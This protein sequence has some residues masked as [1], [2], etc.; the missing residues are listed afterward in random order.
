MGSANK[1]ASGVVWSTI[2]NV[3]SAIYGFI[4]VPILISYFGKSEY[5]LIGL[6]MSV[7]V[8]L[9]LMDL[10]FNSTNVR[11]FSAW[12]TKKDIIKTKKLF[13][14]SLAFYGTIGLLNGLILFIITLFSK[15]LFDLTPEQD[16]ILKHLFYILIV[17]AVISWYSSCFDQLI[18]ATENV[19]W[20]QRRS[21]LPKLLQ[22]VVLFATITFRLDIVWYFL[23]TTFSMFAVIPLYIKKIKGELP[24]IQFIPKF[25]YPILKEILPYCMNIFSF[26]LFQFSFYN[27][28]PVFLGIQGSVESVAD[29]RV[30]N[31][32]I[33]IVSLFASS[34]M[35]ALLPSAS[36]VVAQ[37]NR[38]AYYQIAYDGTKYITIVLCF[39]T[40][41]MMT[42]G[43]EVIT[44]Y[45][46]ESFL[47]LMPW[48]NLWLLCTL[49][50]HNQA[51]S[52]LILSS[53]NI[54]A[55]TY[56][57]SVASI[58]G[59]VSA[60]FLIP[61]Y[62]I[63]GVVIAFILYQIIQLLF[64]Y[65]YYWPRKM[66]ID[67]WRVFSKSFLPYMTCGAILYFL[68]DRLITLQYNALWMFLLK[69]CLFAMVY[70]LFTVMMATNSDK[71]Y[72]YNII[73]KRHKKNS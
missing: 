34:F 38:K 65:L 72:V 55:I 71:E 12:L 18:K 16:T 8:Y 42:V 9:R 22:M 36:K 23:L 41:G 64:Y 30:L 15:Q 70:I 51:I 21:L 29:Y 44:L 40:F 24:R 67:S 28:R 7:N 20:L 5:G 52:S 62:Q 54:R 56:N 10:G 47:Y 63:G 60:W 33:G 11:F 3:V 68:I 43:R 53:S 13:Q 1:V 45:V 39:C 66:H 50:V 27:L 46:G 48:F 25:D 59:L 26:S 31:G 49:G 17:S 37:G 2:F 14:T 19:A 32:V 73:G 35:G 58:V 4:S 69:G 61:Y 6:A 57:T